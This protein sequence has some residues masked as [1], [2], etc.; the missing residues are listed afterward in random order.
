M[1]P[2]SVSARLAAERE[3]EREGGGKERRGLTERKE[4]EEEAQRVL[5]LPGSEGDPW[6]GKEGVTR[7]ATELHTTRRGRHEA[8]AV[9][10]KQ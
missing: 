5:R 6:K 9:T 10:G 7:C 3:R 1:Y 4:G 2:H 8:H